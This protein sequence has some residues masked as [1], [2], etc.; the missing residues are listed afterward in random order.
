M[1]KFNHLQILI[2]CIFPLLSGEAYLSFLSVETLNFNKKFVFF[3][4]LHFLASQ[5]V[6]DR[7]DSLGW[8]MIGRIELDGCQG[9]THRIPP[10]LHD[11]RSVG[12]P[13]PCV[14]QYLAKRIAVLR[15]PLLLVNFVKPFR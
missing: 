3:F 4:V 6:K 11:A 5:I 8:Q 15:K 14:V 10:S 7:P 13:T 2:F 1:K 12:V 9:R